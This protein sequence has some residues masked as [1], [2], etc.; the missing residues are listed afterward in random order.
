MSITNKKRQLSIPIRKNPFN[1]F[2]KSMHSGNM[3]MK[4]DGMR[5]VLPASKYWLDFET[6]YF[7][8]THCKIL[9]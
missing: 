6:V 7:L 9:Q 5:S 1:N 2:Y 3:D 8:T 4:N